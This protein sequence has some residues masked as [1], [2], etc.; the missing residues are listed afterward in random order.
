MESVY[1]L[2]AFVALAGIEAATMA[3]TTVWF[4]GGAIAAFLMSLA[5]ASV[6][7]QLTVF[8]V[9]SFAL[10]IFTRPWAVKHV[11]RRAVKTNADSLV[12]KQARVT[13]EINNSLQTG[14]AVVNGQEWTARANKDGEIYPADTLVEIRALHGVKLIV[15]TAQEE[16]GGR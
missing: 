8:A 12:G 14:S 15:Q 3:L 5:H 9:V 16:T 2:I 13:S 6:N 1:W 10:L 4:A 11:N 7:A